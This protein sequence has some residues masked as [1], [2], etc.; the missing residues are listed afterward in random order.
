[1]LS[2][3]LSQ[4]QAA[5]G[6]LRYLHGEAG[7]LDP[8]FISSAADVQLLLQLYAGL[9]RLDE[10]GEPYPSLAEG[11]S[12]S[13]DGREYTFR[14]RDGLTFSDGTTIDAEDFRRSWLRLLDP[15]TEST[16]PDV[17]SVVEGA[18]ERLAGTA[19]EDEVGIEA[20]DPRTNR[21]WRFSLE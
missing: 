4:G 14:L 19:D 17:L 15:D 21:P 6:P 16:A 20:P 18:S 9:T 2:L 12:V 1:M 7:T 11:W 3:G 10:E 5:S 8:A 13:D